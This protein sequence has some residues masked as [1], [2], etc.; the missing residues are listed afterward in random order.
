MNQSLLQTTSNLSDISFS[1]RANVWCKPT[2]NFPDDEPEF[3]LQTCP[4]LSPIR[5]KTSKQKVKVA[6]IKKISIRWTTKEEA[7]E[8]LLLK[9]FDKD[10]LMKSRLF[11]TRTQPES[12]PQKIS[13]IREFREA[14]IMMYDLVTNMNTFNAIAAIYAPELA[15]LTDTYRFQQIRSYDPSED[16]SPPIAAT[17]QSTRIEDRANNNIITLMG[18]QIPASNVR[19]VV[20]EDTEEER[21]RREH[22]TFY[23]EIGP[24]KSRI[25]NSDYQT[26][27][28]IVLV[29]LHVPCSTYCSIGKP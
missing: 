25:S 29:P 20:L 9:L 27:I 24:N 17:V 18:R 19:I 2:I 10:T 16:K 12:D 26:I 4:D 6:S 7:I 1:K 8:D 11:G 13:D 28:G 21:N 15:D 23:K 5:N 14:L 22:A 3:T